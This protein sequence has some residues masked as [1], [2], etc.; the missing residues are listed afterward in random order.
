MLFF[1]DVDSEGTIGPFIAGKYVIPSRQY[2]YFF[3][4]ATDQYGVIDSPQ[5]YKVIDGQLVKQ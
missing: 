2:D 5:S 4:L 1:C 3:Y